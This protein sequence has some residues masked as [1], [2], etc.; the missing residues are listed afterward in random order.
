MRL[1]PVLASIVLLGLSSTAFAA[2][3]STVNVQ[4]QM[5][6]LQNQIN[7]LEQSINQ[8]NGGTTSGG[9]TAL[10]RRLASCPNWYDS[11][12]VSGLVNVD[13]ILSSR[14]ANFMSATE[15][16][17]PQ[18]PTLIHYFGDR[19]ASDLALD[20]ADLFVDARIN[21]WTKA[22]IGLNYQDNNNNY[23]T[24]NPKSPSN[25][26]GDPVD[27]GGNS[28]KSLIIKPWMGSLI[29]EAYV[30][31]G[32]FC[33]SP[34]YFRVGK[35]Y[36][37]FGNYDR[38][39]TVPTY[40]QL[41]SQTND[42][43]AT[44]GFV[45]NGFYGSVY[46]FRGIPSAKDN[47]NGTVNINNWGANLGWMMKQQG[48]KLNL[49]VG[50]LNNMAD[51]DYVSTSASW[52]TNRLSLATNGYS[53]PVGA[54]SLDIT[55]KLGMFDAYAH[56]V[57]ALSEFKNAEIVSAKLYSTFGAQPSAIDVGA[58][59]TTMVMNHKSRFGLSYD[60]SWDAY[61]VGMYGMPEARVMGT[62]DMNV[63]RNV[64]VGLYVYH[65]QNYNIINPIFPDNAGRGE[66]TGIL[67]VGVMFA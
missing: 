31:F 8:N 43:A 7:Q 59:L 14:R 66:T 1:K 50:Y 25:P 37:N 35:Q 26:G 17:T 28:N 30:T 18:T 16:P 56:Y 13:G 53:T 10:Q 49:Q 57:T 15:G 60:Y 3:K 64:N 2:T 46:G 52:P 11:I 23:V 32:N 27:G 55:G 9:G 24:D 45:Q 36:L 41:L 63:S 4:N 34:I 58:G 5:I 62:F 65:D 40:T 38:F 12:T 33:E 21:K 39:A 51:V 54:L 48:S 22:H 42:T 61:N 6:S 20:N 47:A 44:L 29:D 67:H 19:S